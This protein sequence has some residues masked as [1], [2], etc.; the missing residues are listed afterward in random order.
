LPAGRPAL[1]Q[2][3]GAQAFP[4]PTSAATFKRSAFKRMKPVASDWL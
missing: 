3:R 4:P 2:S 1:L